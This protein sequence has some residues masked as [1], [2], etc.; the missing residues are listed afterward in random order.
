L[1][2]LGD[3]IVFLGVLVALTKLLDV[4]MSEAQKTRLSDATYSFWN[5]IDDWKKEI[6][7]RLS[8]RPSLGQILRSFFFCALFVIFGGAI[9]FGG[10]LIA[11]F[12]DLIESQY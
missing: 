7:A 8:A 3:L 2:L 1:L 12:G 9:I 4:L 11:G 10:A 5:W 6:R